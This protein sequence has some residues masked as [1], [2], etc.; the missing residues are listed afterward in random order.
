MDEF[1]EWYVTRYGRRV[2]WGEFYKFF[3]MPFVREYLLIIMVTAGSLKVLS[4]VAKDILCVTMPASLTVGETS[5]LAVTL[6]AITLGCLLTACGRL[7][8]PNVN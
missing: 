1:S 7:L 4:F 6:S 5:T 3:A 2:G 8:K